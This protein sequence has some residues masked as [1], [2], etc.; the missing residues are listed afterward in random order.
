MFG[1]SHCSGSRQHIP[2]WLRPLTAVCSSMVSLD[3]NLPRMA[4]LYRYGCAR[5]FLILIPMIGQCTKTIRGVASAA[6]LSCYLRHLVFHRH[7]NLQGL[8]RVQEYQTSRTMDHLHSLA[9][10]LHCHIHRFATGPCLPHVGRPM[11]H[12][13]YH[14][15]DCLLHDRAG[16]LVRFQRDNMRRHQALY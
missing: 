16:P 12:R 10:G 4:H 13:R 1:C 2:A 11:A 15:R 9:F 7:C 6:Q 8:C 14:L 5:F 3:F